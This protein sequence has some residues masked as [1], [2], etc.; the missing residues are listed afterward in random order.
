MCINIRFV[1][2]IA[3]GQFSQLFL[4]L[5]LQKETIVSSIIFSTF[6]LIC[7]NIFI[8]Y[9]IC[10]YSILLL[11]ELYDLLVINF[12]RTLVYLL[13]SEFFQFVHYIVDSILVNQSCSKCSPLIE[14]KIGLYIVQYIFF[15][16]S[17]KF[18]S[19]LKSFFLLLKQFLLQRKLVIGSVI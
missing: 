5:A 4:S 9:I 13:K 3:L 15:E 11:D 7:Q 19:F 12:L 14:N 1:K 10:K 18:L 2:L 17:F 6:L 8:L 16:F